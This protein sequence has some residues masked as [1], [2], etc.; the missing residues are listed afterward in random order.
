MSYL[1]ISAMCMPLVLG[2]VSC[3]RPV[4]A[5]DTT[6]MQVERIKIN[7]PLPSEMGGYAPLRTTREIELASADHG[8][9]TPVSVQWSQVG[10]VLV[11]DNAKGAVYRIAGALAGRF[12]S[13]SLD[14][15]LDIPSSM[16]EI[17]G[18][19]LVADEF[20]MAEIGGARGKYLI[21][22]FFHINDFDLRP[23]GSF[24]VSPV[25]PPKLSS[26]DGGGIV[27]LDRRGVVSARR[28]LPMRAPPGILRRTAQIRTCGGTTAAAMEYWPYLF[29]FGPDSTRSI[30]LPFPGREQLLGLIGTEKRSSAVSYSPRFVV[31]VACA[32]DSVFVLLDLPTLTVL[33]YGLDGRL[34]RCFRDEERGK[35]LTYWSFDVR[36][37]KARLDFVS[38]ANETESGSTKLQF[39]TPTIPPR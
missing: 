36:S 11:L 33:Q 22:P 18:T 26:D 7:A 37:S 16:R 10:S 2:L 12:V 24:V 17:N 31:D 32:G 13:L 35:H 15:R 4:K 1:R 9:H 34:Q 23:D 8:I 21:R 30:A 6:A 38:A 14:L 19:V 29:L 27:D 3:D 25:L 5:L 28:P 20:G 39:H